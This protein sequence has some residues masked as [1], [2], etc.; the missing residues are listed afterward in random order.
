[1]FKKWD[2]VGQF[3]NDVVV[4]LPDPFRGMDPRR[5]AQQGQQSG[6]AAR[7]GPEI[8][9]KKKRSAKDSALER[10]DAGQSRR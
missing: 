8:K 10:L 6:H 9:D 5:E 1:M 2:T 3:D 7:F 4:M